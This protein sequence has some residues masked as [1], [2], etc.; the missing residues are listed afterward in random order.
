MNILVLT[1]NLPYPLDTGGS[2]RSY[3]LLKHL[4]E[5][6]NI[7]LISIARSEKEFAWK[8]KLE[9][10]CKKVEL[11]LLERTFAAKAFDFARSFLNPLPYT[12]LANTNPKISKLAEEMIAN[13]GI[14]L[15]QIEELYLGANIDVAE[16][17]LPLVLDAPNI[18]ALILQRMAEIEKSFLKRLFF[19]L[20]ARKMEGFERYAASS[21]DA[22]F[23]VSASEVDYFS[24]LNAH[25]FFVP[26]GIEALRAAPRGKGSSVLFTGTLSYPPNEDALHF[27]LSEIWPRLENA[28]LTLEIVGRK[29]SPRL[30][31]AASEKVVFHTEVDDIAPYFK[32]AKVM[33]VPLRA[34]AGTRFKILQAFAEGIPVVSTAIG[35]E[36]IGACDGKHLLVRDEPDAFADAVINLWQN[37]E[38]ASSL[39]ANAAQFVEEHYSWDKIITT[40]HEVYESLHSL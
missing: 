13:Y 25:S 35:V 33:V 40:C 3:Y 30:L 31:S 23:A 6:H 21:A 39:A 19:R 26:N 10:F 16:R 24:G 18:E 22:V 15:I 5:R 12:V 8:Y 36:G 11:V 9:E 7:F 1:K 20:Q 29:P 17:K 14:D 38:L 28:G 32:Q 34:G 2:I 4:S 27:F 37:E